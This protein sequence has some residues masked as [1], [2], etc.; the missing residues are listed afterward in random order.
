MQLLKD[1]CTGPYLFILYCSTV[2]YTVQRP[3]TLLGYSDEHALKDTFNA[4]SRDDQK[5]SLVGMEECL[6]DVNIWMCK[7]RLQ[8]NNGKTKF[9]YFGYRQMLSLCNAEEI[10]VQGT[11]TSRSNIVRYLGALLE[12]NLCKSNEQYQ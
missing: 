6:K 7:H 12:F 5:R 10:D 2:Q 3:V 11:K 8:M 1:S 9:I 4:K